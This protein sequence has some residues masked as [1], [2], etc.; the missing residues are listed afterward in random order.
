MQVLGIIKFKAVY[1]TYYAVIDETFNRNMDLSLIQGQGISETPTRALYLTA[2]NT[3]VTGPTGSVQTIETQ[4]REIKTILMQT[5]P[6]LD[7]ERPF[8]FVFDKMSEE[9]EGDYD[10]IIWNYINSEL[11]D[12]TDEDFLATKKAFRENL[13]NHY[14]IEKEE[15]KHISGVITG[16]IKKYTSAPSGRPYWGIHVSNFTSS[17]GYAITDLEKG[18]RLIVECTTDDTQES[19]LVEYEVNDV[20]EF[21]V[22]E[23]TTSTQDGWLVEFDNKGGVTPNL[24]ANTFLV[25]YKSENDLFDAIPLTENGI[26]QDY[27]NKARTTNLFDVDKKLE[28]T[29]YN[30]KRDIKDLKGTSIIHD[31]KIAKL[32]SI[33]A[34][35]VQSITNRFEQFESAH[36]QLVSDV[37]SL[38]TNTNNNFDTVQTAIENLQTNS[39]TKA[40]VTAVSD[41][42][43]ALENG[44]GGSSTDLTE[45]TQRVSDAESDIST[46]QSDL[47]TVNTTLAS[48]AD[49]SAVTANASSISALD[50]RVTALENAPSGGGSGGTAYSIY[51]LDTAGE[52]GDGVAMNDETYV[53]YEADG[54]NAITGISV[55]GQT[56]TININHAR[57]LRRLRV[58]GSTTDLPH[59]LAQPSNPFIVKLKYD[60]A[61]ADN[62]Y[63]EFKV[64]WI[65]PMAQ[66]F[67]SG[68]ANGSIQGAGTEMS[69]KKA[70]W[71]FDSSYPELRISTTVQLE[72]PLIVVIN[73]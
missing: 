68:D 28:S 56:I 18:D 72:A 58:Y 46:L 3:T 39:A 11:N 73:F 51:S 40:E 38:N 41:R 45:L 48:K 70:I 32:Y 24:N 66:V 27:F 50:T 34:S 62:S 10:V 2:D 44:S 23:G 35:N 4:N 16:D 1:N 36:N 71:Y 12:I 8:L 64:D 37:E 20:R 5:V 63:D 47:G 15:V 29:F 49:N 55:S 17:K 21:Y 69:I 9:G 60:D 59:V 53:T 52:T 42:V 26:T 14:K 19:V 33:T 31:E 61:S 6:A 7:S 13:E 65:L 54:A 25:V 67:L 43:T 57:S 22:T 30:L